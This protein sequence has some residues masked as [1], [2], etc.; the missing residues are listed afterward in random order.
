M[1]AELEATLSKLHDQLNDVTD[2][3]EGD[4][5]QLRRSVAE[6]QA[7]LDRQDVSSFSLAQRLHERVQEFG[8]SHPVLTREVGRVADLLGQMGI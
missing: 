5:E 6:I 1:R 2:L 8:D 4:A 7:T 3:D